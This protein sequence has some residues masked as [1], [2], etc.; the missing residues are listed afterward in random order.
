MQPFWPQTAFYSYWNIFA[1]CFPTDNQAL[2]RRQRSSNLL[3]WGLKKKPKSDQDSKN[4]KNIS[5]KAAPGWL[6]VQTGISPDISYNNILYIHISYFQK[7]GGDIK[8]SYT[9]LSQSTCWIPSSTPYLT[10]R[11]FAPFDSQ[12]PRNPEHMTLLVQHSTALF[13][14]LLDTS[15]SQMGS[16]H[17]RWGW[18]L[19]L[20]RVSEWAGNP[21]FLYS[22]FPR[23]RSHTFSLID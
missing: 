9:V 7:P 23:S 2:S 20:D 13:M 8:T 5:E 18:L 21:S 16:F 6:H 19:A 12:S 4:E 11:S 15:V 17:K 10:L 1:T 3:F 14:H 22:C